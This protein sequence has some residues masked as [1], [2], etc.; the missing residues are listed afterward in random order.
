MSS[1]APATGSLL[2]RG[3]AWLARQRREHLSE[4]VTYERPGTGSVELSAMPDESAAEI[5]SGDGYRETVRSIDFK[6][7]A[8]DLLLGAEP[9]EPKAGD[10]IYRDV[11]GGREICQVTTLAGEPWRYT[12]AHRRTIRVHTKRICFEK[13]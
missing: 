10:L 11:P 2:A 8:D 12:D 13:P 3:A 1:A 6:F 9:V 4:L 7:S 5:D